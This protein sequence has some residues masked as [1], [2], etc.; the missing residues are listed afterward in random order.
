MRNIMINYKCRK[1]SF[2]EEKCLILSGE[3]KMVQVVNYD[4]ID[5]EDVNE[6]YH[7]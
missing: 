6:E 1:D 2:D 4:F 3:S 5:K 7:D